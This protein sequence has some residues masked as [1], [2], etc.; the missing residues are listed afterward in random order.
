MLQIQGGGQTE[1]KAM[2]KPKELTFSSQSTHIYALRGKVKVTKVHIFV[3]WE[4][5]L[6]WPK[7]PYLCT[8]RQSWSDQ[9][10]HIC[11]LKGKA[12]VVKVHIFVQLGI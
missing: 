5:K 12:D 6:K 9:S 8:E 2:D 3:H 7:Y 1:T 10:T 11:A 4:V